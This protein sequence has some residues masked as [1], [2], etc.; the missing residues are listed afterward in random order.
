MG[1]GCP[2][3]HSEAWDQ[4]VRQGSKPREGQVAVAQSHEVIPEMCQRY[5]AQ[6]FRPL[7]VHLVDQACCGSGSRF[8]RFRV[9][10]TRVFRVKGGKKAC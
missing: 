3:P 4:I 6:G 5:R 10:R 7:L 2:E 9:S 8:L 1:L